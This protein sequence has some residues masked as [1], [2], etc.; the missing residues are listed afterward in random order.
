MEISNITNRQATKQSE[1]MED[2]TFTYDALNRIATSTLIDESYT[3]DKR[4]NRQTL[5]T[6]ATPL[7]SLNSDYA[8]D[9]WDRLTKV[10][11]EEGKEVTYRYNG[12]NLL[13]ERSDEDTTIRY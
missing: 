10:T 12:D 2:N 13:V 9:E 11:T 1:V 8:Y 4:G 6:E 5:A 3:Y 7:D